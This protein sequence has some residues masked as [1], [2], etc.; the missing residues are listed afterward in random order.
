MTET[1][2]ITLNQAVGIIRSLCYECAGKSSV[3][4]RKCPK[5]NCPAY[6]L[7]FAT[8]QLNAFDG[9]YKQQ[10]MELFERTTEQF[11]SNGFFPSEIRNVLEAAYQCKNF[12]PSWIGAA[13]QRILNHG[14]YKTN[15]HR[16][17]PIKSVNGRHE[18]KFVFGFKPDV[19]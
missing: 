2:G 10:W 5:T 17:S 15:E 8:Y 16:K 12:H 7:R 4:M 6:R 18:Y 14:W 19:D 9:I 3:S 11:K 1:I 13:C